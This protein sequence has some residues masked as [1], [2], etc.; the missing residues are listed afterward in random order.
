VELEWILCKSNF[1]KSEKATINRIELDLAIVY[2]E[3]V[4]YSRDLMNGN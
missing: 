1:K 3:T 2:K 4:T